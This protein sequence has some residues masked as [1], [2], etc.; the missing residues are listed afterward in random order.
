M[1][2][3]D[4]TYFYIIEKVKSEKVKPAE[5]SAQKNLQED[6]GGPVENA[7]H[8]MNGKMEHKMVNKES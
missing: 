4:G 1:R 3:K 2:E 6:P 5:R 7:D 8:K